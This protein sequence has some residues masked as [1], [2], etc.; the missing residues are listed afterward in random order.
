MNTNAAER[1]ADMDR[2]S[3][4]GQIREFVRKDNTPIHASTEA[5]ES[6]HPF[7][8]RLSSFIRGE[9]RLFPRSARRRHIAGGDRQHDR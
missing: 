6:T 4:E 8:Y 2:A 1:V 3:L 9:R 7:R 5:S